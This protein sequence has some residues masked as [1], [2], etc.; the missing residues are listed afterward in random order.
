[1]SDGSINFDTKIDEEDFEKGI[2]GIKNKLKGFNNAVDGMSREAQKAFGG[3][4]SS[5]ISLVNQI[6]NTKHKIEELKN[7]IA[8]MESQKVPT[9]RYA[10][11]QGK[12]KNLKS[13][14]KKL[15]EQEQTMKSFTG[16]NAKSKEAQ[17]LVNQIKNV[18]AELLKAESAQS[19]MKS[20]G[21]AF[22]SA[23]TT[24]ESQAL[25][26]DLEQEEAKLVRLGRKLEEIEDKGKKT[27]SSITNSFRKFGNFIGNLG[28]K[29]TGVFNKG[30]KSGSDF[31]KSFLRIGN[32]LK[33][34]ILRSIVTSI[35]N[36]VKNGFQNLA[37]YSN[38]FNK[39][40]SGLKSS[41]TQLGNTIMTA[42]APVIQALI[43]LFQIVI[44]K[45][46]EVSNVI[47]QFTARL[48]GNTSTFTRAKKVTEDYAKS[49]GNVN[50]EQKKFA[51]FDTIE[52]IETDDS[53]G[54]VNPSDMF[55]IANIEKNISDFA[56]RIK[57]A[58]KNGDWYGVGSILGQKVNDIF[59]GI[60]T[61][62]VGAK[63]GGKINNI[64]NVAHGFIKTFNWSN[65]G[66]FMA[67][68]VNG[69]FD[70]VDFSTAA[71]VFCDGVS[72]IFESLYTFLEETDWQMVGDKIWDF[73]SNIDW[74]KIVSNMAEAFGAAIGGFF[75]LI[76]GFFVNVGEQIADFWWNCLQEA[77]GNAWEGFLLGI[78]KGLYNI[79]EFLVEK[80]WKPF[81]EGFC[82]A[83]GIHSPST[84][85]AEFGGFIV[86][87]LK[88][89]IINA[90]EGL[91]QKVSDL[92]SGFVDGIK[93]FFGIH[94]P[95]TVFAGIG[96][97]ITGG[98]EE[99]IGDGNGAFDG[100]N[101]LSSQSVDEIKEGWYG[102]GNWFKDNVTYPLEDTFSSFSNQLNNVFDGITNNIKSHVLLSINYMNIMIDSLQH[103]LNETVRAVNAVITEINSMSSETGIRLPR[104]SSEKLTH[105]P[106]PKLATGAVLPGGSPFLAMVNDQPRG[107]TNVEAPLETIKQ[108]LKEVF[109][110]VDFSSGQNE[111][112]LELDGVQFGRIIYRLNRRESGRVGITTRVNGGAY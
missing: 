45:I 84:K 68:G 103:A 80:V 19:R 38:S 1:M 78:Y 69:L 3:M 76:W 22:Q 108:A 26:I 25:R 85:M 48:F 101:V 67:D 39:S 90:W 62:T 37:Q 97:N 55:E 30:K 43:P 79:G 99:G 36:G 106:I 13:E 94:S 54:S 11:L 4:S 91:K 110:E 95:S 33:S 20:S 88:Q 34:R 23:G 89:G 58:I 81:K 49:L 12:V 75:G 107:Q 82:K 104:V 42:V 29:I 50:K 24:S 63:L 27:G 70:E 71:Q 93:N 61:S 96:E 41:F 64:F 46:I 112:V 109:Q 77:G 87:G 72:G 65:L 17:E 14:Y 2:K 66:K 16:Y 53:N 56:D 59:N 15:V 92:C 98:L 60:D 44:D 74:G 51:S 32:M 10:E 28:K 102:I 83:F 31:A 21:S 73:F 7:T 9:E 100:L 111:A 6:D 105:V 52:Q 86:E 8:E 35:V 57:T 5:Q 47:A 40:I 18:R